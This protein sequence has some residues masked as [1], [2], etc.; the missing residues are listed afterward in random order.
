MS[1]LYFEHTFP[2]CTFVLGWDKGSFFCAELQTQCN[3]QNSLIWLVR[4]YVL[5]QLGPQ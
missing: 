4:A 2:L 5:L 1:H 3:I